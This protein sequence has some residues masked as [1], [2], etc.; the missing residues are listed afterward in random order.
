VSL[1]RI[2]LPTGEALTVLRN[3][4]NTAGAAF[5][6]EAVLPPGLHGPPA[7]WHRRGTET[8]TVLDG[9]LR[10]RVGR[11]RRVV[12]PGETVSVPPGITHAFANPADRPARIRMVETPAGPLEAQFHALAAAGRF[13]PLRRLARINVEH[14]Y[15]YVQHGLPE[16]LQRLLWRLLAGRAIR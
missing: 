3:G 11:D 4:A 16:A 13:P 2:Q 15:D 7:H 6:I 9:E 1:D 12:G 8:F 14:N 10:V 5:E